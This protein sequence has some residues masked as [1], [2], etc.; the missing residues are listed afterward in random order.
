MSK[1]KK[2]VKQTENP[3][4]NMYCLEV[5]DNKGNPSAYYVA[6][7]AEQA[8]KMKLATRE[9]RAEGAIVYSLYGEKRDRI[10]LIR[11]YRYSIDD[12]LYELPAGGIDAG[13]TCIQAGIREMK[14]ETGLDFTPAEVDPMYQRPFFTT[15]GIT[16]EACATVFGYADG[17][18]SYDGLEDM[19]D[20]EVVL[21]D[22]AE[23]RRILKEEKVALMCAY[24]LTQFIHSD[25]ENPLGFLE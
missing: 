6:S 12:Y 1:V 4:L 3:F 5:K 14:E 13:E 15:I 7:R 8:Y 24:L 20:I 25:P 21:A 2:V 17:T 11:Q 22:R 9:H 23:A 10:V 18:V 16:D 19:E